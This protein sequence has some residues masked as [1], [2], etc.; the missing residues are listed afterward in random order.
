[1]PQLKHLEQ[2]FH[3]FGYLKV[4]LKRKLGFNPEHFA[5]NKNR[6]QKCDYTEVY[7]DDEE[8]IP[9][10]I[11]VAIGNFMPTQ[12]FVDA[13]HAG[14]TETRQYQ[15]GILFFLNSAPIIWFRNKQKSTEASTFGSY[16][17]VMKNAVEIIEALCYKL[18]TFWV[19][20]DGSTNIFC[21]NGAVYVNTTRLWS[22]L[23]KKHHSIAYHQTHEGV[24]AVTIRL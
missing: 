18:R 3:I 6:L 7:R 13:N 15:T 4:H 10:N 21:D 14:D 17:T 5:I 9:G 19:T 8:T 12:Y 24:A 20:I 1:M 16:L 2:A 22:T 23:Y 11:T